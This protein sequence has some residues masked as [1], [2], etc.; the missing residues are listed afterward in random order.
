VKY[1]VIGGYAVN[2][3]GYPRATGDIDIWMGGGSE[4]AA[5][6]AQAVREFGFPEATPALFAEPSKVIRMGLP[7]IRIEV[8]T[9]IT[10]VEFEACYANR[11]IAECE[12]ARVNL[13]GLDDLKRNKKATGRLK[14]LADLEQ[15]G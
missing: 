10:G 11:V 1:L 2:Y 12:G 15:L 13:I 5:R 9:S 3:H 6:M 8:L 7:P 14:D 4:N